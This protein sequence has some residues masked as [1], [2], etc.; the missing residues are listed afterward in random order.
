MCIEHIAQERHHAID[1]Y[2]EENA[3]D[4]LLLVRF[5]VVC[6]VRKDEEDADACRNERKYPSEK[7]TEVMEGEAFPQRFLVYYLVF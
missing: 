4:M 7:E 3:N 5:E 1:R 6:R 2:E